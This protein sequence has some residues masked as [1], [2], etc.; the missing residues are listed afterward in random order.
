[1]VSIVTV[2]GVQLIPLGLDQDAKKFGK[3][4]R[5]KLAALAS[6]AVTA[7]VIWLG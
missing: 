6:V 2:V 3:V 5:V 4:V 1:M 7:P